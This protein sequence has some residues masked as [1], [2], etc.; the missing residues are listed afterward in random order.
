MRGAIPSGSN[1]SRPLPL[2]HSNTSSKKH[3]KYKYKGPRQNQKRVS[4][5]SHVAH[6]DSLA[7]L[8]GKSV[9]FQQAAAAAGGRGLARQQTPAEQL[10]LLM[11]LCGEVRKCRDLP[12]RRASTYAQRDI[13]I[14]QPI[15]HRV[16]NSRDPTTPV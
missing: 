14:L 16:C 3:T 2:R 12:R 8:D 1:P 6:S 7:R 11:R 10:L 13:G 15:Q 9:Q 4:V 5:N